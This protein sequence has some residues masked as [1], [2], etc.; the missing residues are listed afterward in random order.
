MLAAEPPAPG[1]LLDIGCGTGALHASLRGLYAEYIGCDVVRYD[2]FDAGLRFVQA[3]L[4]RA[5]YPVEDASAD[6]VACVET[7][8]HLE[9]PRLV[10]RELARIVRPGG[11]VLI[12][13]PN[14]LSF[15]SKLTLV[16]KNQFQGFRQG[17]YPA[18][19]TSLVEEDLLHI[20]SECGLE[21]LRVE[22]SNVG[23]VPRVP[24]VWPARAGFRGR[25][26]SDNLLVCGRRPRSL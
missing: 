2:G 13:T 21:Q 26:F 22:Y 3:D 15:L 5:P 24:L 7:I 9:N 10:V 17:E 1:T 11:L 16:V 23:R 12:T 18:H 19:I 25:A 20:L 6:V 8:E 14:V 4:N